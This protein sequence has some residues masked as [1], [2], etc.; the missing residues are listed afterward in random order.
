MRTARRWTDEESEFVRLH[1]KGTHA[2]AAEIG[3]RLGRTQ[4]AVTSHISIMGLTSNHPRHAWTPKQDEQLREL[5]PCYAASQ[6]AR[7]MHRSINSVVVRSKRL[8][9]SRRTHDGWY[10]EKE[11]CEILAVDHHWVQKRIDSGALKATYHNGV[12][13]SHTGLAMWHIEQTD[14]RDFIRRHP[15]ELT[16]RNV[17]MITL[18]EILAGITYKI[19]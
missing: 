2:S 13:P 8:G 18:V 10:T 12:R 14:L 11:V 5:S 17:D 9:I 7:K 4:N 6:I 15:D 3:S 1:Y 19:P 16:G